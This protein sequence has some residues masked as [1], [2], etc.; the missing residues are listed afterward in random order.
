MAGQQL[1]RGTPQA[2]ARK[3]FRAACL[4]AYAATTGW[5]FKKT[6]TWEMLE[7]V[8]EHGLPSRAERQRAIAERLAEQK[9]EHA[10]SVATDD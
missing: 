10:A 8:A 3:D 5:S 1:L 7:Y 4:A 2:A 9:A 6:Q